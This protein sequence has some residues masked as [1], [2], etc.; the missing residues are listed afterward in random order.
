MFAVFAPVRATEPI[1]VMEFDMQSLLVV[2]QIFFSF[3]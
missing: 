2:G 3:G 1:K